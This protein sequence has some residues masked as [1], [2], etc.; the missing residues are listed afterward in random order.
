MT[1]GIAISAKKFR[2][3]FRLGAD[4]PWRAFFPDDALDLRHRQAELVGQTLPTLLEYAQRTPHFLEPC[5]G[6]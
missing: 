1:R 6:W 2:P 5:D 3:F 4:G